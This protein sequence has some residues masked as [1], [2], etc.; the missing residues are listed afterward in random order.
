MKNFSSFEE[1]ALKLKPYHEIW[2]K[3]KN[4][5]E[6]Y[7]FP[8]YG[9]VQIS[10]K[11]S[12][13]Y[14]TKIREDFFQFVVNDR[15][16]NLIISPKDAYVPNLVKRISSIGSCIKQDKKS[17]KIWLEGL[18]NLK[19]TFLNQTNL[20]YSLSVYVTPVIDIGLNSGYVDRRIDHGYGLPPTFNTSIID[21]FIAQAE[22]DI[23]FHEKYE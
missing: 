14:D 5:T 13:P 17:L 10:D 7:D 19:R 21:N 3:I 8:H 12:H 4:R 23:Q 16:R 20:N 1:L 15:F 6:T 9:L 22:K 2:P 11:H 18:Y